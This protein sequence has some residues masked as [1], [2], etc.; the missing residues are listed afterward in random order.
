MGI[1]AR[2]GTPE[3]DGDTQQ[4]CSQQAHRRSVRASR[5]APTAPRPRRRSE[6]N[7]GDTTRQVSLTLTRARA[8]SARRASKTIYLNRILCTTMITSSYDFSVGGDRVALAR[9]DPSQLFAPLA[10]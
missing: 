2:C 1:H 9:M 7:G 5:H 8:R 10:V 6:H 4:G 3:T